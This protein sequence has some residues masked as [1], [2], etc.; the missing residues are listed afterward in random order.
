MTDRKIGYEIKSLTNMIHRRLGY[1]FSKEEF[2]ELT[3]MQNAVLGH[4]LDHIGKQDIFQK[5]IEKAFNIRRSTA[6]VMIQGLEQKGYL[7]RSPVEFDARLKKIELT[8]KAIRHQKR[9]QEEFEKFNN[10]LK[11][12]FSQKE[13]DEFFR[14]IDKL[15]C[16]LEEQSKS[17]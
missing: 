2:K 14:L 11:M 8:D 5:D 7:T 17:K 12:G 3:G 4:V 16:N 6:T 1:V 15:K 10:D 13:L 9:V